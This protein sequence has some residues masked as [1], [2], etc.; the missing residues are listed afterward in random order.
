MNWLL[1]S[2]MALVLWGG[3]GFLSKVA[4]RELP[5]QTVY[6]L[7]IC[8][9]AVVIG[10]LWLSGGLSIAGHPWGLAAALGA[11][12]CMALGLLFFLRLSP[13]GPPAWWSPSRPYIPW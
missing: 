9:H 5:S 12:L 4:T 7:S 1:F 10:Y 3:W 6:L 13:W 8:G 2:L 11:G